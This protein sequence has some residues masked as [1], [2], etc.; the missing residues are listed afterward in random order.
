MSKYKSAVTVEIGK[1]HYAT[2]IRAGRH[3]FISDEPEGEMGG[4][5]QGPTPGQLLLSSL[6]TCTAI[7]VRMYADRKGW[8]LDK[9]E[10]EL[11]LDTKEVNGITESDISQ[12]TTLHGDL[13]AEQI[14]RLQTISKKCPMHKLL[15]GKISITH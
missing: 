13:T 7:T 3:T 14:E 8:P 9:V 11:G 1:E 2:T 4:A 12:K 6:G 15:E 10:V 5:D